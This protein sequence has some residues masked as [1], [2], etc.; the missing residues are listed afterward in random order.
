MCFIDPDIVCSFR[1]W[2]LPE[3]WLCC[4]GW[5]CCPLPLFFSFKR[6]HLTSFL[7]IS[8]SPLHKSITKL[9]DTSI[10]HQRDVI[11]TERWLQTTILTPLTWAC[12]QM[13]THNM[14]VSS[15]LPITG[16]SV[17]S[18][19]TFIHNKV[20][21]VRNRC[22]TGESDDNDQKKKYRGWYIYITIGQCTPSYDNQQL[23]S[24]I[25]KHI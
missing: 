19:L 9:F 22:R 10:F 11:V 5:I 15:F 13:H 7:Q 16:E 24:S 25:P 4:C 8:L 12:T 6:K 3:D 2:S 21:Y 18:V 23:C 20:R 1:V 14:K 17:I